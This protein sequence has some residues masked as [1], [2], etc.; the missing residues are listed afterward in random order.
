MLI[1]PLWNGFAD[2]SHCTREIRFSPESGHS[3]ARVGCQLFV[4]EL[5]IAMSEVSVKVIDYVAA[6]SIFVRQP[7]R[8]TPDRFQPR[9]RLAWRKIV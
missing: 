2:T 8:V 4:P 7:S 5:Q 9:I 6:T 3:P 1:E